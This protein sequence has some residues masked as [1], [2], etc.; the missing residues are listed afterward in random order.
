VDPTTHTSALNVLRGGFFFVNGVLVT[1]QVL[2]TNSA[3]GFFTFQGGELDTR[4][5]TVSNTLAFTIG[6]GTNIATLNL[7]GGLHSF[8]NGVVISSNAFLTGAGTNAGNVSCAG[9]VSPG[10][11]NSIASLF[12]TGNYTQSVS[13]AFNVEIGGLTAGAQFDQLNVTGTAAL[14]GTLNVTFTNG[15]N[16][17]SGDAFRIL[18]YGS[19]IGSFTT[20]NGL[21][22]TNGLLLTAQY[23]ST[24]LTLIAT[25]ALSLQSVRLAGANVSFD[26]STVVGSTYV[27]E[28]TDSLS[29]P[30]WRTLQT[31]VGDGA[32]HT[33]TDAIAASTQRFYRV[34]VQ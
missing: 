20:L 16:P 30:D 19:H 22:A 24:N 34:R 29:P 12:I 32:L 9:T 33:I 21:H 11:S 18:T 23:N 4:Q 10:G 3:N 27:V 25:N 28:W 2:L 8:A 31:V 26:I 14:A 1:D 17:R 13:G 5:T 15:F 7:L 6:N